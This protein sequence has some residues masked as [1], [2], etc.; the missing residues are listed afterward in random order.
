MGTVRNG[1]SS[2]THLETKGP[3]GNCQG[4]PFEKGYREVVQILLFMKTIGFA[5]GPS[6]YN[7]TSKEVMY[8]KLI[9]PGMPKLFFKRFP[10]VRDPPELLRLCYTTAAAA[11]VC[12]VLV[13][14][15]LLSYVRTGHQSCA[16]ILVGRKVSWVLQGAHYR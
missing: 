9:S 14:G 2:V 4:G 6:Q 8:I 3:T 5:V 12:K 16:T 1:A 15:S 13:R 7:K 10:V 11:F